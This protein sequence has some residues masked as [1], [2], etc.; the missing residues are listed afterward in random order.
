MKDIRVIYSF[1]DENKGGAQ[2]TEDITD[3][4]AGFSIKTTLE[5]QPGVLDMTAIGDGFEYILGSMLKV[6]AGDRDVFAGF[7]FSVTTTKARTVQITA[8]DALRYLKSKDTYVFGKDKTAS[9]IFETVCRRLELETGTI[10]RATWRQPPN[11]Y[12]NAGGF[13][14]IREAIGNAL[15]H[16][17]RLY[18]L[19]PEG[20]KIGFRNLENLRSDIIIDE[21]NGEIDFMHNANI[22][23]E[24]YSQFKIIAEDSKQWKTGRNDDHVRQW[25]LLQ[26]SQKFGAPVKDKDLPG[27]LEKLA[28]LYDRPR[29]KLTL[30]CFGDWNVRAGVGVHIRFTT[31]RDF[32][33]G[34]GYYVRECTHRVTNARHEMEIDL[35]AQNVI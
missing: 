25:G 15:A 8:Y 23:E 14:V 31:F 22:D 10:D 29:Q 20:K 26:Y 33:N 16:E 35:C 34:Q 12:E 3:L 9:D 5:A 30:T 13:D 1:M 17:K 18:V 21:E 4:V 11:V 7:I 19:I 32:D 2:T 28:A 27:L 24:T 6:T